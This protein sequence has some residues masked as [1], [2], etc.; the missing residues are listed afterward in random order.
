VSR[1]QSRNYKKGGLVRD[2][3]LDDAFDACTVHVKLRAVALCVV[4]ACHFSESV[5]TFVCTNLA[6]SLCAPTGAP[7]K[8]PPAIEHAVRSTLYDKKQKFRK[9]HC[10][11]SKILPYCATITQAGNSEKGRLEAVSLCNLPTTGYTKVRTNS[12]VNRS[13]FKRNA[14]CPSES[15][16]KEHT[17][18]PDKG[19]SS[20]SI[21][22]HT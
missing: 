19:S 13:R 22:R 17:K 10:W 21:A 6:Q 2:A 3:S 16:L 18:T 20:H 4:C 14:G 12:G 1:R 5:G 15:R 11:F 7:A 8:K 9:L